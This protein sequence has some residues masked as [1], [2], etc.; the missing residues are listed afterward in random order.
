MKILR[1]AK[2]VGL[3]PSS[4]SSSR[5]RNNGELPFTQKIELGNILNDLFDYGDKNNEQT[6]IESKDQNISFMD[7]SSRSDAE[8]KNN[9]LR[10]S[11]ETKMMSSGSVLNVKVIHGEK[12]QSVDEALIITSDK[13]KGKKDKIGNTFSIINY[14]LSK[15]RCKNHKKKQCGKGN[16]KKI[17]YS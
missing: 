11:D 7:A 5:L 17:I 1:R 10:C 13:G 9:Y 2:D 12:S 3:A 4:S 14:K 8:E 16:K 15:R 6:L